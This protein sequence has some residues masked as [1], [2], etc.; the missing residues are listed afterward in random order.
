MTDETNDPIVD[1]IRVI[2]ARHA[3]RFDYD[4]DAIVDY[5]QALQNVYGRRDVKEPARH[6]S[7]PT[8]PEGCDPT[9]E[10]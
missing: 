3:A 5:V 8:V 4:I 2:R 6:R 7:P 9:S 10:D 1:E